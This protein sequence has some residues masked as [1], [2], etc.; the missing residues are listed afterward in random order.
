MYMNIY[1][2]IHIYVYIYICMYVHN[3]HIESEDPKLEIL[4][5]FCEE[6]QIAANPTGYSVP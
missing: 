3:M 1:I 4:P 5:G 2:Y 6:H